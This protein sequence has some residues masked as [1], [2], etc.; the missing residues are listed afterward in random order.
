MTQHNPGDIA[1]KP[2]ISRHIDGSTITTFHVQVSDT[3]N[4]VYTTHGKVQQ[5]YLVQQC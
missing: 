4:S 3:W 1:A 5:H 2:R